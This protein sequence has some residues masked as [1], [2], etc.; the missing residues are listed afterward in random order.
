MLTEYI[1]YNFSS[2]DDDELSDIEVVYED[3]SPQS[4]IR[5]E[6]QLL[7]ILQDCRK[8]IPVNYDAF[9]VNIH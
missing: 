2:M 5:Q 1:L 4:N 7:E 8:P 3:V 9:K 6:L